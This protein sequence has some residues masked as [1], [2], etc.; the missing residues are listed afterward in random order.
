MN[1]IRTCLA[2]GGIIVAS[3]KLVSAATLYDGS[4]GNLPS[5]QALAYQPDPAPGSA[6]QQQLANGVRLNT[7]AATTDKAGY[8][9]IFGVNPAVPVMD[10]AT[11]FTVT[12]DL[13]LITEFHGNASRAGLNII[14]LGSD[15]KGIE[16]GFW[17]NEIW[18]QADSPLFQHAEG[19]AFDTTAGLLRY[20]L[21]ISG[22]TYS[23]S[24]GATTLLTGAVRDYS[25][26]GFFPY[27]QQNFLFVG[28]DTTSADASFDFAYLAVTPVPEPGT[29]GLLL[30]GLGLIG[31]AWEKK[32]RRK[33]N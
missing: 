10:R 18:A 8:F 21:L 28:D 5:D 2:F 23:L 12:F 15:K 1:R 32:R 3:T 27:T 16:L 14:A 22:N 7:S 24:Q 17:A 13:R 26:V 31:A 33:A 30:V 9:G 11:G 20:D 4:A 29:V 6:T 19:A 25:S